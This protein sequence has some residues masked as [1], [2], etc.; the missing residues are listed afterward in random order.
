MR[1][2]QRLCS[3]RT[4]QHSATTSKLVVR[5]TSP[6]L[7]DPKELHTVLVF[8]L[9]HLFGDFE[10]HSYGMIVETYNNEDDAAN[11]KLASNTSSSDSTNYLV[12]R[13]CTESVPAVRASLTIVTPPP[14]LEDALYQLDVINISILPRSEQR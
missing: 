11:I 6:V 5:C 1:Q 7:H 12:I 10:S 14:Y 8:S 13:C 4:I 2:R 3:S 9:R